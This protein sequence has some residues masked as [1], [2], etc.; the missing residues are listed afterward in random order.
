MRLFLINCMICGEPDMQKTDKNT[1]EIKG[2]L[3]RARNING[4]IGPYKQHFID[5]DSNFAVKLENGMVEISAETAGTGEA[6][7]DAVIKE[8]AGRFEKF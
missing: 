2:I 5:E 4:E 3:D 1:E 6:V 7:S 8:I